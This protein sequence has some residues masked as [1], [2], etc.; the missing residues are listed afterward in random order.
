MG[1]SQTSIRKSKSLRRHSHQSKGNQGSRGLGRI[2]GSAILES[3]PSSTTQTES[4]TLQPRIRMVQINSSLSRSTKNLYSS[5]NQT[6]ANKV[7]LIAIQQTP[8]NAQRP[9]KKGNSYATTT[10]W[11]LR[12]HMLTTRSDRSPCPRQQPSTSLRPPL[13]NSARIGILLDN[14]ASIVSSQ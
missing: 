4:T 5:P 3:I 9:P 13:S 12:N 2:N 11:S 14:P 7:E 1:G 8:E 6:N 10:R